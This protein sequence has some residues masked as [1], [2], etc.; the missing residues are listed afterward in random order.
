MATPNLHTVLPRGPHRLTRDE[1]AASQRG[2]MLAAMA[3]VVADRGYGAVSVADVVGRAGVSR[4]TFYAHFQDKLD[5]FM[6][7]YDLGVAVL[8]A[9]VAEAGAGDPDPFAVARAR[10]RSYL[11][12][13]AAEPAFART[14]LIEINAAGP[15]AL[16]RRREVHEQFARLSR[17]LVESVAG[18]P[19]PAQEVY[20]AQVGATNE[21]VSSWVAAGRAQD[22]PQLEDL[23]LH[24]QLSLMGVQRS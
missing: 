9:T 5:C 6:A 21:V 7:A 13:L 14:F 3:E 11:A 16:E 22:L 12:T 4:K 18:V 1:V 20:L 2:R 24:I 17:E 10:V 8:L 23:V 19:R 15:R